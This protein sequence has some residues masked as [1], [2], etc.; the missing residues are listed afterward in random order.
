MRCSPAPARDPGITV[1][2]HFI[3]SVAPISHGAANTCRRKLAASR[4]ATPQTSGGHLE[5][6]REAL[7]ETLVTGDPSARFLRLVESAIPKL[8]PSLQSCQGWGR[9]FDSPRLLQFLQENQ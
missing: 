2:L 9:E 7:D 1:T 5:S 8:A 3:L 6:I 4:D